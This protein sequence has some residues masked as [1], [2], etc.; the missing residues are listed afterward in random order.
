M[1][2]EYTATAETVEEATQEALAELGADAESAEIEIL[3]EPE[4]HLFGGNK[5]AIVRVAVKAETASAE[6]SA[7]AGTEG[8]EAEEDGGES[9]EA[10]KPYF[11]DPVEL[12]DE[13]VDAIADCGIE[14]LKKLV[15]FLYDKEVTIEEFEGDD[16][17]IILDISG[18][19][20]G[21]LIGRHGRTIDALQVVVSAVTTKKMGTHY[22]LSIDVE[23]YK[24]RR[25]QKVAEIAQRSAERAK[26]TGRPVAL[27]AMTAQERRIVHMALREMR[28]VSTSSEGQ[29]AYRHVVITPS[30]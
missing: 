7:S 4:K 30:N 26:R 16:G 24:Y 10:E 19:D 23:G 21:V 18:D 8:A 13:Q 28:G 29:G 12:T 3:Q 20:I 6:D 11:V 27:K 15:S 25:K 2:K 9:A 14:T 1:T 17:E 5:E 22:P